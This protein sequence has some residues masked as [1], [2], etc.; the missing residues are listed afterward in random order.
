[1]FVNENVFHVG[2]SEP[3]QMPQQM[4]ADYYGA[5]LNDQTIKYTGRFDIQIPNDKEF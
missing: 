1:M 2:A 5:D 3:F 4:D